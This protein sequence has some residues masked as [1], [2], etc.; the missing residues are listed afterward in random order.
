M[1]EADEAALFEYRERKKRLIEREQL[2]EQ[3]RKTQR[4]PT[5]EEL[6]EKYGGKNWGIVTMPDKPKPTT[7]KEAT[8]R[9]LERELK[10][11]GFPLDSLYSPALK[12]IIETQD[13]KRQREDQFE[14]ESLDRRAQG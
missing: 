2:A 12:E 5:L 8:D 14:S 10:R 1:T 4:R 6:H 13:A 3:Q 11:K 9:F 7:L